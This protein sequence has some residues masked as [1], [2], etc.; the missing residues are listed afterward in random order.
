MGRL[1]NP[2]VGDLVDRLTILRLKI[3]QGIRRGDNHAHFLDEETQINMLLDRMGYPADNDVMLLGVKLQQ[4]NAKLW[5]LEDRMATYAQRE[6]L[7]HVLTADALIADLAINIWR[8][9][10][11]RNTLIHEINKLAGTPYGPEKLG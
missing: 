9:N 2:G 4:C 7:T 5:E 6:N 3:L 11:E 8:M 1:L 10:R